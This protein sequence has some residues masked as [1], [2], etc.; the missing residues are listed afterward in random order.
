[1]NY[2]SFFQRKDYPQLHRFQF[3]KMNSSIAETIKKNFQNENF[4]NKLL[5]FIIIDSFSKI[6]NGFL[7]F[8]IFLMENN[9][10]SFKKAL[11]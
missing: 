9:L 7:V 11:Q 6:G 2:E 8:Q 4:I 5:N 1:M 3:L 10:F